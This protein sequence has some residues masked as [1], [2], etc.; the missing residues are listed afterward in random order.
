MHLGNF[1]A[2]NLV[3]FPVGALALLGT[4][5][6]GDTPRALEQ[7]DTIFPSLLTVLTVRVCLDHG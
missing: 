5:R 3:L 7:L 4:I 2:D 6:Y 1:F